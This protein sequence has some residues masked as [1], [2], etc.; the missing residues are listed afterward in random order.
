MWLLSVAQAI[1][2]WNIKWLCNKSAHI[3][4]DKYLVKSSRSNNHLLLNSNVT[5]LEI[6]WQSSLFCSAASMSQQLSS[7]A[8]LILFLLTSVSWAKSFSHSLVLCL[9]VKSFIIFHTFFFFFEKIATQSAHSANNPKNICYT[10]SLRAVHTF[11]LKKETE[12][13]LK[14][15]TLWMETLL[16]LLWA[17]AD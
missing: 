1:L 10:D 2:N 8:A 11:Y 13:E 7:T 4:F 14:M 9:D 12:I 6:Q 17:V 15:M 5:V 16:T 3:L